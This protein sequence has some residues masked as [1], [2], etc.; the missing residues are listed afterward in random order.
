MS[1][2]SI[3]RAI[4]AVRLALA[5]NYRGDATLRRRVER[6]EGRVSEVERDKVNRL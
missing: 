4:E 1:A 3:R 5:R 2:E 6:L